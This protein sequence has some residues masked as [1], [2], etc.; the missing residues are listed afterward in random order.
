MTK[1]DTISHIAGPV[2]SLNGRCLQRCIICG[3]KIFDSLES[4]Y[5]NLPEGMI[6]PHWS[7]NSTVR[8]SF[9]PDTPKA[10]ALADHIV[11]LDDSCIQFVD[12]V[13]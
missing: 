10:F 4:G 3:Q 9:E 7:V 12:G 11:L 8:V 5:S 2:F 13:L 1:L 6:P